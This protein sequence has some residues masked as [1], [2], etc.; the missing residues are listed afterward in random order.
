LEREFNSLGGLV[1][2]PLFGPPF[3]TGDFSVIDIPN[4][5]WGSRWLGRKRGFPGERRNWGGNSK[6]GFERQSFI[7]FSKKAPLDH[8]GRVLSPEE[9]VESKE[10]WVK[11][12]RILKMEK[13]VE[14]EGEFNSLGGP[15]FSSLFGPPFST[16]N[17]IFPR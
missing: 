8:W 7:S 14:L 13:P 10:G 11:Q 16:G 5:E 17:S 6:K 9:R 1:F 2:S 15:V 3:S 12:K 4:R